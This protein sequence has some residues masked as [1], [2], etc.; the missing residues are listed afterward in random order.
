MI[1][2]PPFGDPPP[3][4][5]RT[6]LL[7]RV[8]VGE[9]G[10][11]ARQARPGRTLAALLLGVLFGAGWI[12]GKLATVAWYGLAWS[13]SAVQVGWQSARGTLPAEPDIRDVLAEN[14]RLR[15]MLAR[16]PG[17]APIPQGVA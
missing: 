5:G 1:R 11:R 12:A 10:R 3:E 9:I 15:R 8:P 7:D 2:N 6:T 14:D 17:E 13:G 16:L 4:N